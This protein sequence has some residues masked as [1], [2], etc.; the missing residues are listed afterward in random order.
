[1]HGVGVCGVG[2]AAGLEDELV[3]AGELAQDQVEP[4]D[5]LEHALQRLVVLVPGA[6]PR[7][8]ARRD[9]LGDAAGCTSSCTCRTG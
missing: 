4:V 9:E 6:A 3:H 7:S 5:E 8:R 2:A 1:M